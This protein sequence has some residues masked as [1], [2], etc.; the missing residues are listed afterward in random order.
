MNILVVITLQNVFYIY[1]VKFISDVKS[2]HM[3]FSIFVMVRQWLHF[4][5]QDLIIIL[6]TKTL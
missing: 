1:L 3:V 2:I 5:T 6:K 4:N